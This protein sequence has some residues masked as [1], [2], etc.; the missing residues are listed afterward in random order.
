MAGRHRIKRSLAV[1]DGRR[2]LLYFW[3]HET[4]P[5]IRN[6]VC[7]DAGDALVWQAELPP[8]DH[9]DCFVSLERDGDALAVR[10]FS[11]HRLTLCADTGALL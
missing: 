2:V 1:A 4:A 7:V 3:G 5:R 9:P 11:G 10:T 6:L 8:S